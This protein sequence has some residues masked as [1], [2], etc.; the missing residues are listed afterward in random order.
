[1]SNWRFQIASQLIVVD[2]SRRPF[3]L[4]RPPLPFIA[5][6]MGTSHYVRKDDPSDM[7]DNLPAEMRKRLAEIGWVDEDAPVNRHMDRVR[8]PFSLL[9][10]QQLDRL[11][12]KPDFTSSPLASPMAT[13][14][15]SPHGLSE[16]DEIT[17][18]R[19]N[20][21]TGGPAHGVKR[22]AVF[23]PS[24]ARI[25]PMLT[26][27]VFDDD[28]AVAHVAR[29]TII[30]LMRN[31]PSLLTRPILDL[32]AEDSKDVSV[33]V[34]SFRAFLHVRNTLP[35]S[36][37]HHIFNYLTGFLKHNAKNATSEDALHD[38]AY[39]IPIL[40]KLVPQ[41]SELSLRDFRRAK[42]DLYFI[43]SGSLFFSPTA[44]N[45]YMFPQSM[46]LSQHMD[47]V[48]ARLSAVIMVRISQNMLFLDMLKKN[49]QDVQLV[50]KSM[51]RLVLPTWDECPEAQTLDVKDFIPRESKFRGN[52]N[53]KDY[54][55]NAMSVLL[56]RSYL[57]LVAQIFRSM[58]RHLNDR[59]ELA[60][61]IDGVNRILLAH[62]SDI[63]IVSQAL[64]GQRITFQD[65]GCILIILYSPHGSQ[66]SFPPIVHL[67]RWLYSLHASCHEGLCRG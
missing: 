41:V 37:A 6:D 43:P 12:A 24:V 29:A 33:A 14:Q 11:D 53:M 62:G 31:D 65:L 21:S 26:S 2:R 28:F 17:L 22:R 60:V 13:P 19:R 42:V 58:S 35:P 59:S 30:D 40:A 47:D 38:Y 63:G 25:F 4:A 44:A 50:R 39:V 66:H 15:K 49:P 51:V 23:V 9:P 57:P 1:M 64:I 36:M 61:L 67:E 8:T 16:L 48:P 32:L 34:S 20:S 10:V 18:L 46:D 5:T 45:P 7:K 3:K 52:V 54:K 27:M 56:S 55:L